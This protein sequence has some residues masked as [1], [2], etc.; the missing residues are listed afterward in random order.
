[1]PAPF[2]FKQFSVAHDQCA[3]K[4]GT[5]GVLLGAWASQRHPR[6]I[7]DVGTGSGVIALMMAQRFPQ[8]Q[9]T[10]IEL[11]TAS[12]QQAKENV[13]KSAFAKQVQILQ[14][15]FLKYDF[16]NKYDL[17]LSN[18]PF[19]KGVYSSGKEERDR[20]RHEQFLPQNDFLQK[21]AELLDPAGSL[22]IILPRAEGEAFITA[23]TQILTPLH[24]HRKCRVHGS[25][26]APEKRLMLQF[27]FDPLEPQFERLVLRDAFGDFSSEYRQLTRDF[28]L[29]F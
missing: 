12:A 25:P 2:R 3:H 6:H 16:E 20:A 18:P 19:F 21:A 15:D 9:V 8:T 7:L 23:A 24:L 10:G 14:G 4:V 22:V 27:G 1:M 13:Q 26:S 11:H 17:I 5:D 29:H 28:Y